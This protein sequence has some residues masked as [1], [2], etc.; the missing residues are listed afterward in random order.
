[1]DAGRLL[2]QINKQK[3]FEKKMKKKKKIVVV[4]VLSIFI[5]VRSPVSGKENVRFPDSQD[6]EKIP[7][8]WN[9][10]DVR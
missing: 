1:M 3:K 10:H 5:S 7:D 6:F 9:G 2:D 4:V 8:L